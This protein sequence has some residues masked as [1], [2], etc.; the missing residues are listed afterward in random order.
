MGPNKEEGEGEHSSCNWPT[1]HKMAEM[2]HQ[3]ICGCWHTL[4]LYNTN[5]F[6]QTT[7]PK[8]KQFCSFA[9]RGKGFPPNYGKSLVLQKLQQKL[10]Q[11]KLLQKLLP[12]SKCERKGHRSNFLFHCFHY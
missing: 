3:H 8:Y 12:S 4:N 1:P 5:S 9:P 6:R 11:Q 10:L 7:A 2:E